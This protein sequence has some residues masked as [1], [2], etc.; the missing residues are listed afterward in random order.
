MIATLL[1]VLREPRVVLGGLI[2]LAVAAMA[3]FA[4]WLAPVAPD[5]QDLI[6]TLLPPAW[7]AGGMAS[8]FLGTDSLGRDIL[9]LTIYGARVA[10]FVG[11]VAPIG[12]ALVGGTLALLAG[13]RGGR[14]DWVVMRIVETWMSFP[15]V[16]LALILMV[17]L[18]PSIINVV[19]ALVFVDWTRFCRVLRAEVAVIRRREYVAAARIA[20]AGTFR[21]IAHDV[22][23]N[24]MPTLITLMSLEIGIAVVAECS[25]S[26][27]G[28]SAQP[29]TPTWGSMIADGLANVFT[30]P[31][32]LIAPITCIVVTVLAT[33]LLGEGLRRATDARL[34]V[35]GTNRGNGR[36]GKTDGT[37]PVYAVAES[38]SHEA[39]PSRKARAPTPAREEAAR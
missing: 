34:L 30:T 5:Q 8:H 15:A 16:V 19:I 17:A 13:W 36:G 10:M 11:C 20:G 32:G 33:T 21:T 22:L 2:L 23:P 25:L 4:P 3:L 18:S 35:R 27:V 9:S 7:A 29:G 31:W 14:T 1:H 37:R 24:M 28:L 12:A 26:F 39:R 38:T 6:N